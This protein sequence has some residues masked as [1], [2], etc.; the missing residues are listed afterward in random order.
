[1]F[2]SNVPRRLLVS[3]C[4][5]RRMTRTIICTQRTQPGNGTGNRTSF[6][7]STA[8]E[9]APQWAKAMG[10]KLE[11]MESKIQSIDSKIQFLHSKIDKN[12]EPHDT[13]MLGLGGLMLGVATF[14]FSGTSQRIDGQ[15]DGLNAKIDSL[16]AN[17]NIKIDSPKRQDC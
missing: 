13:K 14:G 15:I 16:N 10:S 11:S 17:Q 8:D 1:M 12:M 5:L 7:K 9:K 3:N 2:S 4:R 6:D